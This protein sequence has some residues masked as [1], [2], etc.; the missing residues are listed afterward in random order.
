MLCEPEM[1]RLVVSDPAL[2]RDGCS[3]VPWLARA[4]CG[5]FVQRRSQVGTTGFQSK[6]LERQRVVNVNFSE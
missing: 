1:F 4:L 6:S 5:V 3:G 2:F